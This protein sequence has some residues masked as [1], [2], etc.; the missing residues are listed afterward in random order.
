MRGPPL[1]AP[2]PAVAPP[3]GEEREFPRRPRIDWATLHA[4]TF[5]LDVKRRPCGGLTK[6]HSA[7]ATART[8][9]EV[10]K[11]LG[12]WQPRVLL[13]PPRGPPQLELLQ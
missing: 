8:A 3:E 1:P 9:E 10:L 4:R 6:V 2:P 12:L 7:V 5:G 11:N 13:P